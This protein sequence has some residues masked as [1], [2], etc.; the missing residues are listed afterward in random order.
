VS[1]EVWT[2]FQCGTTAERLA[3]I[4]DPQTRDLLVPALGTD[5]VR[6]YL[7]LASRLPGGGA[8]LGHDAA[9]NLVFVPGVMG[10]VLASRGLGGVWWLDVRTAKRLDRLGLTDDGAG[11]ATAGAR[12][13]AVAVDASYDAFCTAALA[14]RDFGHLTFPYDWRRPVPAVAAGLQ[15]LVRDT[16]AHNGNRPVHLVAHSMGGLVV[17]EA[18][19]TDPEL[20]DRIGRIA[21]IATPHY[22]SA[23]IAGYLKNHLWGFEMLA[24]L[25]RYLSRATLRSMWGVLDLLPAPVG[26]YP[27]SRPDDP[28]SH[29]CANFDLYEAAA[30]RL[31]LTGAEQARL[32]R[33]L[34]GART[35]HTDL[36]G[37]HRSLPQERRERML[38]VS[39]VGYKTLFRLAY[40]PAFGFLW[41]HMDRVTRRRPGDVHREGDGRVPLASAQLE[42]VGATHYV[43]G[44]HGSL[45]AVPAVQAAVFAWL[46]GKRPALP[47]TPAAALAATLGD[48]DT[49]VDAPGLAVARDAALAADDPGYLQLDP[50]DEAALRSREEDVEADRLPRFARVKVL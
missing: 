33:V 27:G 7:A 23:A 34:D 19:R 21:F 40:Q 26:V 20:W 44:E 37:W 38:V 29:P 3:L 2:Q 17:R 16:F 11:D 31:G 5:A 25:G 15:E 48:G 13:E 30:Y 42:Y 28:D 12:V 32:Q 45:P 18:L 14:Q 43:R 50:P 4:G 24:L 10:S 47:G 49:A 35:F 36:A 39:G 8:H 22:G 6:G 46:R 9:P 41:E 1:T